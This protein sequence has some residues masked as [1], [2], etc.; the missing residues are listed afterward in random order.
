MGEVLLNVLHISLFVTHP[1]PL[2]TGIVG[3]TNALVDGEDTLLVRNG[4]AAFIAEDFIHLFKGK[5]LRLWYKEQD[6]EPA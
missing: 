4:R 2:R 5:A 3:K 1:L 6:E